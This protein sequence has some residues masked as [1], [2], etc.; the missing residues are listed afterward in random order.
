MREKKKR[1]AGL[2]FLILHTLYSFLNQ[3]WKTSLAKYENIQCM[4][5]YSVF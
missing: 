5:Y 2:C 1:Q 4:F 3:E